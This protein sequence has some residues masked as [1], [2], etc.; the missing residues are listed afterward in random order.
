MRLFCILNRTHMPPL[1]IIKKPDNA[2]ESCK[3]RSSLSVSHL[4][5]AVL[6]NEGT[7]RARMRCEEPSLLKENCSAPAQSSHT[8]AGDREGRE[9]SAPCVCFQSTALGYRE[10]GFPCQM[11]WSE[12]FIAVGRYWFFY[13]YYFSG[14]FNYYFY[15]RLWWR[16]ISSSFR[17]SKRRSGNTAL[18]SFDGSVQETFCYLTWDEAQRRRLQ[19]AFPLAFRLRGAQSEPPLPQDGAGGLPTALW[20]S[21]FIFAKRRS[22]PRALRQSP[23]GKHRSAAHTGH[24]LSRLPR[25][26]RVK[27]FA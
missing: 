6:V 7:S 24:P 2:Y 13:C 3:G 9:R 21:A 8:A 19:P 16:L 20:I 14:W 27:L 15:R 25:R 18:G 22:Q 26:E 5:S 4:T 12:N 10:S 17:R 23:K 11:Y 1:L